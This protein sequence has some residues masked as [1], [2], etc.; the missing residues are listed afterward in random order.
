MISTRQLALVTALTAPIAIWGLAAQAGAKTIVD[1]AKDA[2]QFE[3]LLQAVEAAGLVETLNGDGPFTIFAPTDD[4]F[5]QLP[6]GKLDELLKPENKEE[7]VEVLT[8]HIVPEKMMAEDIAGKMT[9][10]ES[11]QGGMIEIDSAG[12]MTKIEQAAMIQPD[13]EASNG[14]IHVIDQ[15][16]LPN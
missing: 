5:A 3:T 14:V 7:L 4:A 2:G 12:R 11:V 1:T 10:L 6:E 13:I 8:F 9:E 15:V 16:I